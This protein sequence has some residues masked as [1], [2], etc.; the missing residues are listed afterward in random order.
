VLHD[1][2]SFIICCVIPPHF[3][4]AQVDAPC[5]LLSEMGKSHT[6]HILLC[7]QQDFMTS[8]NLGSIVQGSQSFT[9]KANYCAMCCVQQTTNTRTSGKLKFQQV[10]DTLKSA[11]TTKY[12]MVHDM[13]L[14]IK[15]LIKS[16]Y[17]T[18]L[19]NLSLPNLHIEHSSINLNVKN[20][21]YKWTLDFFCS[22]YTSGDYYKFSILYGAMTTLFNF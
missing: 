3:Q 12:I 22:F 21:S 9:P 13:L 1:S 6:M 19:S 7:K 17:F 18:N 20:S 2:L 10:Q 5:W 14:V 4:K 16:Y 15:S 8:W 11:T